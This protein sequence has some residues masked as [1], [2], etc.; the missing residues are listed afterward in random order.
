ML[1]FRPP[2]SAPAPAVGR[3]RQRVMIA[4]KSWRSR[5]TDLSP[6]TDGDLAVRAALDGVG[7]CCVL[8]DYVAPLEDWAPRPMALYLYYPSRRQEL[9]QRLARR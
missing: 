6:S 4:S 8:S 5:L 7:V 2:Y 1:Q 3:H 9:D